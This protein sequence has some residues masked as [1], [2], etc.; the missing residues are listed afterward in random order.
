MVVSIGGSDHLRFNG[1]YDGGALFGVFGRIGLCNVDYVFPKG[2]LGLP[3]P[4]VQ[5]FPLGGER[6]TTVE[7][8][9]MLRWPLKASLRGGD[10]TQ[11]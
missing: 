5:G 3:A 6:D 7:K 8:Y 1:Q 10:R 2:L 11:S 9:S 4:I